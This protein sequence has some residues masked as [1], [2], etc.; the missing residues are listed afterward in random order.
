MEKA[1]TI[2]NLGANVMERV[3]QG[4]DSVYSSLLSYKLTDNVEKLF[5]SNSI[6]GASATTG[7]GIGFGNGLDNSINGNLFDNTLDGGDGNDGLA[8]DGVL[9]L[10]GS[11]LDPN[12]QGGNDLIIGG[13]GSDSMTGQFG[14]DILI[15]GKV[16]YD[17]KGVI[18]KDAAGNYLVSAVVS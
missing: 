4:V 5:L 12:V 6:I 17:T 7:Y 10:A 14:D 2:S 3:G 11:L 8:G 1:K 16:T 9:S 18:A 15:G 13:N